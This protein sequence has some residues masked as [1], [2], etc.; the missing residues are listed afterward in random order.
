MRSRFGHRITFLARLPGRRRAPSRAPKERPGPKARQSHAH[1][2]SDQQKDKV[3]GVEERNWSPRNVCGSLARKTKGPSGAPKGRLEPKARESH[4]R[5]VSD[6]QKDKPAGVKESDWSP[7]SVFSPLS[8]QSKG[9]IKSA[10]GTA[11]TQSPSKSFPPSER[12]TKRQV[13]EGNRSPLNVFS[14]LARKKRRAQQERP[15]NGSNRKPV[16]VMPAK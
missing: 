8:R 16:K 11:R 3:V 1:Q 5:Q 2:V 15:R 6:R 10:E 14:S 4:A 9:P 12:P 7:L 13:K